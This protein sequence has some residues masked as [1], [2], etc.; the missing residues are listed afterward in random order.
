MKKGE[1]MSTEQKLKISKS[2]KGKRRSIS[3]KI[4]CAERMIGR[5]RSDETKLKMSEALKGKKKSASHRLAISISK[6]GN[7]SSLWRGGHSSLIKT[8]RSIREYKNWRKKVFERDNYTCQ[9]CNNRG[10]KGLHVDL[11]ADHFP[12]RFCDLFRILKIKSI[13]DARDCD[14]LWDIK[15]GRTLCKQC[16]RKTPTYGQKR[17]VRKK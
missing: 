14:K 7:K 9:I 16:H 15:N 10:R 11:E 6:R 1:K 8:A 3:F 13:N 2:N 4:K 5:K 12:E 17:C